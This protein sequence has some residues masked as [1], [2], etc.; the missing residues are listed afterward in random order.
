M[1][2]AKDNKTSEGIFKHS[3]NRKNA[4]LHHERHHKEDTAKQ[5]AALPDKDV[6][7]DCFNNIKR[8]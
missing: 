8:R 1:K 5:Q 7:V 3:G 2:C 6:L 4:S